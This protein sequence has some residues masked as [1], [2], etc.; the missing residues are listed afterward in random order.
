MK[1]LIYIFILLSTKIFAGGGDIVGN[2]GGIAE[3]N[4]VHAF[5]NLSKIIQTCINTQSCPNLSESNFTLLTSIEE[6]SRDNFRKIEKLKFVKAD[7]N[8]GLFETEDS[9]EV[10]LAVTGLSEDAPIY[11]NLD[12]LYKTVNGKSIPA[13][14]VGEIVSILVHESGHNIGFHN[15]SILDY[16]GSIIRDYISQKHNSYQYHLEDMDFELNLIN[17]PEY[18]TLDQFWVSW[19]E[20]SRDIT[21]IIHRNYFCDD[22]SK[23]YGISFEN[24]HRDKTQDYGDKLSL[25]VKSWVKVTC[26]DGTLKIDKY[27]EL[28]LYLIYEKSKKKYST[29][30]YLDNLF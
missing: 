28:Y 5:T 16:L 9:D 6:I 7:K 11:I 26:F 19:G 2:G 25:P 23:P 30:Y 15:H 22:G 17:Y 8:P 3:A 14:D 20:E 24:V 18:L 1:N 29:N 4:F 10:R 27:L 21:E 13:I 12:L